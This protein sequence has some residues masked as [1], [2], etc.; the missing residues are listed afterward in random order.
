MA[1]GAVIGAVGSIAGGALAGR[2][3]GDGG[4]GGGG[5]T[6]KNIYKPEK[7]ALTKH[8]AGEALDLMKSPAPAYPGQMYVDTTGKEQDYFNW[9][10]S[11]AQNQAWQQVLGGEV[12]YQTGPEFADRY[13]EEGIRPLWEAEHARHTLPGIKE[14]FAGPGYWGSPRAM[15]EH[16]STADLATRLAAEKANLRYQETLAG[17][18]AKEGAMNRMLPGTELQQGIS[19]QAGEL[20]RNIQ[21]SKV[22]ADLQ[23]WL[24]GEEVGGVSNLAYHP[25]WN[26]ALSLLGFPDKQIA[27]SSYAP[28]S[29][30][31]I[32]YATPFG[33]LG[34]A[35]GGYLAKK[36]WGGG[37]PAGGMAGGVA[38]SGYG[39][40][41]GQGL[42]GYGW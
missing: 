33:K 32:D 8:L 40:E 1:W 3:G 14:S 27:G 37:E 36:D 20:E 28:P 31:G 26:L 30:P 7:R 19:Y 38:G 10:D 18:T 42:G 25:G 6:T 17:R 35:F 16:T 22:L 12:P 9:V 21:E 4:G 15:A 29:A 39:H 13:F 2:G 23:R 5:V 41:A 34:E 24:M 11:L